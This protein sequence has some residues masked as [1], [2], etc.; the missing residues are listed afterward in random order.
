VPCVC[1]CVCVCAPPAAMEEGGASEARYKAMY[2]EQINPFAQASAHVHHTPFSEA[3]PAAA[4]PESY[5]LARSSC[6]PLTR[7]LRTHVRPQFSA[8]E[9][10]R[11]YGELSVA[12]KVCVCVCV[13]V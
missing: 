1:V 7:G 6:P 12:E 11:R 13:C 5:R 2:E 4:P 8:A 9:K 3:D 10:A